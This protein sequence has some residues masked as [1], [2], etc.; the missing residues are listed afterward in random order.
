MILIHNE[1]EKKKKKARFFGWLLLGDVSARSLKGHETPLDP[2]F[3]IFPPSPNLH[4]LLL[5]S[6]DLVSSSSPSSSTLSLLFLSCRRPSFFF[7][8]HQVV[9]VFGGCAQEKRKRKRKRRPFPQPRSRSKSKKAQQKHT[10]STSST[11]TSLCRCHSSSQ[12][13]A[14]PPP[15]PPIKSLIPS[16]RGRFQLSSKKEPTPNKTKQTKKERSHQTFLPC[17]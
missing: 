6:V 15:R 11:S 2:F 8:F 5:S 7:S 3:P 9:F 1:K 17:L 16:P 12:R 10:T 14:S 13:Q 4:P